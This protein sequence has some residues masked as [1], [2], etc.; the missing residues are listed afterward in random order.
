MTRYVIQG[1]HT[2][3]EELQREGGTLMKSFLGWGKFNWGTTVESNSTQESFE[4]SI[5]MKNIY[6]FKCRNY[7]LFLKLNHALMPL[8]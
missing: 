1:V 8:I 3:Q 6:K 2:R 7:N 4:F 5:T